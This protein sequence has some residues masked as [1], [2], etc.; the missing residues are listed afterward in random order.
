[1]AFALANKALGGKAALKVQSQRPCVATRAVS[2]KPLPYEPTA[3]E[4]HMSASTFEVREER[5]AESTGEEKG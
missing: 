1:M 4:P 2:L 5:R 3:L